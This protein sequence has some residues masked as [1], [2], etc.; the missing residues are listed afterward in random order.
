MNTPMLGTS[1]S[2]EPRPRRKTNEPSKPDKHKHQIRRYLE[3]VK[4]AREEKELWEY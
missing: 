4:D 2:T 1:E 3:D